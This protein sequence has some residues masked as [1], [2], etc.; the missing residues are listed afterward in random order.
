MTF[1]ETYE[2]LMKIKQEVYLHDD[3]ENPIFAHFHD[4]E[5]DIEILITLGGTVL[6]ENLNY[7]IESKV[8]EEDEIEVLFDLN[9]NRLELAYLKEFK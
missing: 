7:D 4:N 6:Y 9:K 5:L 3:V 2:K 1:K 8:L